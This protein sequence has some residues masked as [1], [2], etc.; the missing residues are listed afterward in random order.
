M[1]RTVHKSATGVAYDL[2]FESITGRRNDGALGS[3]RLRSC[4][5]SGEA[6][7][8]VNTGV[9]VNIYS[10]HP[11][12]L[13]AP[14]VSQKAEDGIL[15]LRMQSCASSSPSLFDAVLSWIAIVPT[16]QSNRAYSRHFR[17]LSWPELVGPQGECS[18]SLP[19][20]TEHLLPTALDI[21]I[22]TAPPSL[23]PSF[24]WVSSP[25]LP[26][27]VYLNPARPSPSSLLHPSSSPR[28]PINLP[29]HVHTSM[30]SQTEGVRGIPEPGAPSF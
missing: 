13:L 5:A 7:N 14:V 17:S 3:D 19:E 16:I 25:S 20:V 6:N 22:V 26:G 30:W 2:A 8:R 12:M 21:S 29:T 23:L 1:L 24:T 28:Q 4:A 11:G 15:Q 10:I 9:S 18:Q 27:L